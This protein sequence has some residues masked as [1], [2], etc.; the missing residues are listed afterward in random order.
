MDESEYDYDDAEFDNPLNEHNQLFQ[1]RG[2]IMKC[3]IYNLSDGTE[4]RPVS[5]QKQKLVS[6]KKGIKGRK[7]PILHSRMKGILMA[8]AEVYMLLLSHMNVNKC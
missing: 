6:F 4:S 1:T 7:L 3:V 5:N 2:K 8:S